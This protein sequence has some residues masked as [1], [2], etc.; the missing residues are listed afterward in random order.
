[1]TLPNKLTLLRILLTFVIMGLLFVPGWVAKA[2]ALAVFLFAGLTDWLD[3]LL[4]RRWR[5]TSSLGALLDPIADKVLVLGTFLAFV[6]LGLIPAWMVLVIALREFLIT[7]VRLFAVSRR[8]VLSAAKEGKHKTVSQM[9]TIVVLLS[10]LLIQE[11]M[12]ERLSERAVTAMQGL[13]L[14]CLWI[15]MVLTV[16]SGASFFWRHRHVLRDAVSR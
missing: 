10:V 8:L 1:M 11:W 4:A 13:L 5:Q 6:Q 2:A 16:I 15:A 12:G 14:G 9:V 7:G 3:G